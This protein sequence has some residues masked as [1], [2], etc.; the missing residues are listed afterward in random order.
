MVKSVDEDLLDCVVY[1]ELVFV[2]DQRT[3]LIR[4][5]G[6]VGRD[7]RGGSK[8]GS[9]SW[10]MGRLWGRGTVTTTDKESYVSNFNYRK[11]RY[12][13]DAGIN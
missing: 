9:E 1:D 5:K 4:Y 6:R 3:M 10:S 8:L 12:C 2:F 7:G 11:E 13:G